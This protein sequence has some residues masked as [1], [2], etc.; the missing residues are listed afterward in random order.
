MITL[1]AGLVFGLAG[2]AAALVA[3]LG[4]MHDRRPARR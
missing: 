3:V 4:V 2:V 1:L